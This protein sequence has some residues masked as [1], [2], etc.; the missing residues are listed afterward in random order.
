M[1]TNVFWIFVK[2]IK[3]EEGKKNSVKILIFYDLL[4]KL[5]NFQKNKYLYLDYCL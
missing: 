5:Y 4:F 2:D 3:K 1:L